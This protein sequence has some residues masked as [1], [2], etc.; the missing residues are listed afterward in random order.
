MK[1]TTQ[2]ENM[3]TLATK[4][5]P[6]LKGKFLR[7]V[8]NVALN[9]MQVAAYESKTSPDVI[10]LFAENAYHGKPITSLDRCTNSIRV[11]YALIS[12]KE[13]EDEFNYSG[14]PALLRALERTGIDI[15]DDQG[16]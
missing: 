16:N 9:G 10:V 13:Y 7:Y 6:K 12:V 5:I 4:K 2:N 3:G 11:H 15:K 14:M 1:L 8:G